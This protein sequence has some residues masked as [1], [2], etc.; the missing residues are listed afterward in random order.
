MQEGDPDLLK[1]IVNDAVNYQAL[2]DQ[3][4]DRA[5]VAK[6]PIAMD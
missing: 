4:T 1:K 3:M 6:W 2:I 5:L